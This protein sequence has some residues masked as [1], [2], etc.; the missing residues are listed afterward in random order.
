MNGET[1]APDDE[2]EATGDESGPADSEG[3]DD[4]EDDPGGERDE[5]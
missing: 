1:A 3:G 2:G 4:G 5:R